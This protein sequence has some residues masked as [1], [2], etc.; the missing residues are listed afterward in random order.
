MRSEHITLS[1]ALLVPGMLIAN[2]TNDALRIANECLSYAHPDARHGSLRIFAEQNRLS[3]N[4]MAER[5]LF[6]AEP[7]NGFT[8]C[9]GVLLTRA[10]IGG[11]RE[12]HDA[13]TALPSLEKYIAMPDYCAEAIGAYGIITRFSDRYFTF[14]TNVVAQGKLDNDFY[15]LRIGDELV[16]ATSPL[17]KWKRSE[18][19][20]LRMKRILVNGTSDFFDNMVYFDRTNC[21]SIPDYT[22]S[23]EHVRVQ[24]KIIDLLDKKRERIVKY[25]CYRGEWGSL[26]DDEW[27]Q[28]VTNS[29]QS[30][31]ARVMAL[32]ENERLNMTAILDAKIAAI[33]AAEARAARREVWKRRLCLGA[34]VLPIPVIALAAIIARRRRR[35]R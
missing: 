9:D 18:K 25:S 8:N 7:A 13:S 11:I 19:C 2:F 29:C 1:M 6:I 10:A 32:P 12:F 33:E 28:S 26:S 4:E 14:M 34:L 30:E 22:N 15:L 20:L 17:A 23:I 35:A 16:N 24:G 5:L 3:D 31:I 27:C 21:N